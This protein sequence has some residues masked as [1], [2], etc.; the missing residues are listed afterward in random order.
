MKKALQISC[1]Y[2]YQLSHCSVHIDVLLKN[3]KI[4][5]SCFVKI[6]IVYIFTLRLGKYKSGG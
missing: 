4:D 1:K 5:G 6:T 2:N 3:L